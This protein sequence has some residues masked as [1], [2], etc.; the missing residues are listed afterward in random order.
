MP[1][2]NVFFN[3]ETMPNP[4]LTPLD[5]AQE[6]LELKPANYSKEDTIREFV[7]K[8]SVELWKQSSLSLTDANVFVATASVENDDP[9]VSIN[10]NERELFQSLERFVLKLREEAGEHGRIVW[11]TWNGLGFDHPICRLRAIKYGCRNLLREMTANRYGD[12]YHVDWMFRLGSTGMGPKWRRVKDG[13]IS[14]DN[15]ARFFGV[16]TYGNQIRGGEILEA[17]FSTPSRM[18]L[19][20]VHTRSRVLILRDIHNICE[21]LVPAPS[22]Q[23]VEEPD[24]ADLS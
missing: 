21:G 7:S 15:A 1:D 2:I 18:D 22:G 9:E 14:L 17:F 12:P 19:I 6:A 5:F 16:S 4:F 10:S 3:V 11:V 13:S 8:K 24:A 20:N 23:F